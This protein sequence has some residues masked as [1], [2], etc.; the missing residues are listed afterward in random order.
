M[1]RSTARNRASK[2]R[3]A[4]GKFVAMYSRI[5][6]R[7]CKALSV[8]QPSCRPMFGEPS[9]HGIIRCEATFVSRP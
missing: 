8:S 7:S 3:Y 6:A 9:R 1:R 5:S 4:L 2:G